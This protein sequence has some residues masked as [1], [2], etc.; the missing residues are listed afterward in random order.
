[1]LINF[2]IRSDKDIKAAILR[3]TSITVLLE[4][5]RYVISG[6]QEDSDG[7]ESDS[8]GSEYNHSNDS[9]QATAED[10]KTYIQ[11][12]IDLSSSINCPAMDPE[13]HDQIPTLPALEKRNAHDYYADL[14]SAKF[15]QAS[16]DLVDRL[17][18]AN[19]SRYQ[20]IQAE[21]ILNAS[22]EAQDI[23]QFG[24]ASVLAGSKFHDSGLGSSS[25]ATTVSY[26]SSLTDGNRPRIPPLPEEARK[27]QPF[28]CDVCGKKIRVRNNRE[29]K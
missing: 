18:K 7:N 16:P 3:H 6:L 25:A 10:I 27:G 13:Y 20:R 19:W 26:I 1:M 9:I 22:A 2:V 4:E 11:C 15:P 17:G 28:D 24:A 23:P 5:S 29:W 8:D 21:R 12:L 14:I